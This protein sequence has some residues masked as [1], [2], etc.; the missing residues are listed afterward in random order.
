M[1]KL[2]AIIFISAAF[3]S[4]ASA[5]GKMGM[6]KKVLMDSLKISE[7]AADSVVSIREQSMTQIKAIMKD[8]SLSQEQKKE[9]A[10]PIKEDMR[11]RLEKYLTKDQMAK[12]QEMQGAMRKDKTEQ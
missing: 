2:F 6:Q 3:F 4:S 5:Q 7:T 9:K 12:L 8:Q 10:K 1:K 11:T